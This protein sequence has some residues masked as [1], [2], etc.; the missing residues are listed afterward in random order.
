MGE[1][2]GQRRQ[3]GEENRGKERGDTHIQQ[4]NAL[5]AQL[6]ELFPGSGQELPPLCCCGSFWESHPDTAPTT[7]VLTTT[8][9]VFSYQTVTI[10]EAQ[11]QDAVKEL[12]QNLSTAEEFEHERF[13]FTAYV[14]ALQTPSREPGLQPSRE[15]VTSSLKRTCDLQPSREPETSSPQ[16]N[17]RPP[18][19]KRTC[20]L[21]P[22]REHVT[23]SPQREPETSRPQEN[24]RPPGLKRTCDLQ[25]SREPETS[26]PQE[27]LRPPALKR[28]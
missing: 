17:L 6:R 12:I 19:L 1:K 11:G 10:L 3:W 9:K 24:L 16:E 5:R 23:S 25:P 2:L 4:M 15:P 8:Q 22:S 18:G 14:Q 7:A 21:Q 13:V 27:N 28:T 26:R 20:D